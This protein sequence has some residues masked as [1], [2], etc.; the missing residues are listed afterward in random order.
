MKKVLIITYYWP[1]SGGPGVQRVLKFVKYLAK[2]DWQPIILTV[3]NG[4]YPSI[5]N[6]LENDIP[7]NCIVYK[8]NSL[9]PT[10]FYKKITGMKKDEKIPVAVLSEKNVNWKKK[11]ANWIRL[12]FFIPDAKVG[13]IPFAVKQGKEI[14]KEY[15]PDIIFSSSPPQTVNLIAKKLA[16]WSGLKWVADF[17]DPWTDVY[18]YDKSAKFKLSQLI[19]NFQEKSV[20]T[21]ADKVITVS[22]GVLGLLNE[23]VNNRKKFHIIP[24]GYDADDFSQFQLKK[25]VKFT[26][27]YGGKIN[28]QQNPKILWKVLKH[29]CGKDTEFQK[30]LKIHLMGNIS[31][32]IL[33]DIQNNGL[34]SKLEYSGYVNH[35]QLINNFQSASVLLLLIPDT[36]KNKGILTGK[37]F[38]YLAMNKFILG[39]GPDDGDSAKILTETQTG[40]MINYDNEDSLTSIIEEQYEN[41]KN[42]IN[43]F[44]NQ[45]IITSYSREYLTKK[46]ID[47]FESVEN[48]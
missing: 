13:W 41:W 1:P 48:I 20:L 6:T 30:N 42:Q 9:E 22:S 3:K 12:N 47:I 19:D 35:V 2:F 24:N 39:F 17:R 26:I 14:M 21:I 43:F 18:H 4:E 23:K 16:K 29:F 38:E 25:S 10:N 28:N 36:D 7:K 34:S 37:L 32:S 45:N 44:N 33:N 8:T 5:D 27:T 15:R 46:L 31:E 11:I 40:Q